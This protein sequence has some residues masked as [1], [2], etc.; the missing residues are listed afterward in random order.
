MPRHS[1]SRY[2]S[3]GR[4]GLPKAAAPVSRLLTFPKVGRHAG[5][6]AEQYH[7]TREGHDAGME[8]AAASD[9]LPWGLTAGLRAVRLNVH[10]SIAWHACVHSLLH[11]AAGSTA[12]LVC[13]VAPAPNC[14]VTAAV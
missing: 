5:G 12:N 9:L 7:S 2:V 6:E 1:W 10:A 4:T 8:A 11:V 14:L 3:E 13:P